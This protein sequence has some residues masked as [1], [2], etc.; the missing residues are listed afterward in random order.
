[1]NIKHDPQHHIF[2]AYHENGEQM[3]EISYVC[4]DSHTIKADHT[5]VFPAYEGQGIAGQLLS[6]LAD[7]ARDNS[8]KIIPVCSYVAAAFKK[9]PQR[10]QDVA[11]N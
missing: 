9:N 11:A 3:G 6:A 4:A 7:Y 8:L 2:R 10:Y 5:V 1:M